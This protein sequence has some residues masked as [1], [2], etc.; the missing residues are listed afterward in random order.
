MQQPFGPTVEFGHAQHSL[1]FGDF[2]RSDIDCLNLNIT[3]P[4]GHTSSSK[5]PVLVFIHGGGYFLGSSS[6]PQYRLDRLVRLSVE[7][8]VPTVVVTIK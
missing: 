8:K 3:L 1:P 6:W 7:K 4:E 2:K 5:L